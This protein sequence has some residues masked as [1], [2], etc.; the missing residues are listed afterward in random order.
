MN[1]RSRWRV[2]SDNGGGE[3]SWMHVILRNCYGSATEEA[4]CWRADYP[5]V[6]RRERERTGTCAARLGRSGLPRPPFRRPEGQEKDTGTLLR[7]AKRRDP[8]MR[9]EPMARA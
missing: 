5:S 4:C 9:A 2:L 6:E 1:C 3:L 8:L 7:W